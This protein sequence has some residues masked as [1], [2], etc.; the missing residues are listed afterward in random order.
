MPVEKAK[1]NKCM[2]VSVTRKRVAIVSDSKPLARAVELNLGV[3]AEVECVKRTKDLSLRHGGQPLWRDLDLVILAVGLLTTDPVV[4]LDEM[5]PGWERRA[6]LLLISTEPPRA[7]WEGE[8]YCLGFPFEAD[9]FHRQ[10]KKILKTTA[11]HTWEA[12]E[13]CL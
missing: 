11:K 4:L 2:G 6:P 10:V 12:A 3:Y 13:E 8:L 7:D 1:R 9:E 5:L